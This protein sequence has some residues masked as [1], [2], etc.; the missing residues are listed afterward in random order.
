MKRSLFSM[1]LAIAAVVP[2]VAAEVETGDPGGYF[3]EGNTC[4]SACD[5]CCSEKFLGFVAPTSTCH[6]DYI[7]PMTNPVFF[8]DPRTLSEIRVIFVHHGIPVRAPFNGGSIQL[9][10]AQVR[11]ALTDRLSIIATKDG[12]FWMPDNL[13]IPA[14][15]GWA[16]VSAGLKYNL[17]VGDCY[18]SIVSA[19]A[20]YE[21]PV[22]SQR[23]LQGN[24]DGEFNIFL[25]GGARVGESGHVL[26]AAGIRLPVDGTQET[27][28]AY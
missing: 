12:Y 28:M 8:E 13:P 25:T 19:G 9:L 3:T 23:T 16:D 7:S 11:A 24:G 27:Q 22:G 21:L 20:T 4:A 17:Y 14:N 10:A 1:L 15:D 26:S 6:A 18:N 5:E 2:V